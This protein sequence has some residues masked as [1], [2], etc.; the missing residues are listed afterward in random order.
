MYESGCDV[1][2]VH[3]SA[4]LRE[5]LEEN[6]AIT[7]LRI[8]RSIECKTIDI[9]GLQNPFFQMQYVLLDSALHVSLKCHMLLSGI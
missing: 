1:A 7:K 6:F 8:G 4:T 9:L 3:N 2:D 5:V